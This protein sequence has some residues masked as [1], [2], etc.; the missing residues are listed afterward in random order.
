MRMDGRKDGWKAVEKVEKAKATDFT[1]TF[2]LA[3]CTVR[4]AWSTVWCQNK[5]ASWPVFD[6]LDE[7]SAVTAETEPFATAETEPFITSD[8]FLSPSLATGF[9][10]GSKNPSSHLSTHFPS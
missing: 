3:L 6:A 2:K 4:G 9:G 8:E 10:V 1:H 5:L 7:F